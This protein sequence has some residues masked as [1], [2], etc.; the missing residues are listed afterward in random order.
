VSAAA[1]GPTRHVYR[2]GGGAD[3]ALHVFAPDAARG[4][5]C[6]LRLYPGV[7]HL[8]S[9]A[10][11]FRTQESGPFDPDPAALADGAART[12]QSPTTLGYTR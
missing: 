3:L 12:S 6:E 11:A 2:R 9:G 10:L 5:R 7:G 4:G 1:V 8:L